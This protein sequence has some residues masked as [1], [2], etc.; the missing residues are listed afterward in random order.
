MNERNK[1]ANKIRKVKTK[2][3]IQ[4]YARQNNITIRKQE[5]K[6]TKQKSVEKK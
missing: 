2:A 5:R 4:Q 1:K 3:Q 6:E